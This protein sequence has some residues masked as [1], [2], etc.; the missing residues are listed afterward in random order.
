MF[1]FSAKNYH[2]GQTLFLLGQTLFH[3]AKPYF[4]FGQLLQPKIF[5]YEKIALDWLHNLNLEFR[6]M[7]Q[8]IKRY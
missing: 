4:F 1:F 6:K 2:F 8:P 7:N 5:L 3:S